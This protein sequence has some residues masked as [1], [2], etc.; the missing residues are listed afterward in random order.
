M[1]NNKLHVD[2]QRKQFSFD[3]IELIEMRERNTYFFIVWMD[4]PNGLFLV[5]SFWATE[6]DSRET[7]TK[8]NR[9]M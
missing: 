1:Q 5:N 8:S 4:A 3:F 2:S 9:K 6:N 7:A